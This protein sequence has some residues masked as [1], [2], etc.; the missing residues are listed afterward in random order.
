MLLVA[1]SSPLARA[2]ENVIELI[3]VAGQS[4]AVGFD[5]HAALLPKSAHDAEVK[6]WFRC[7]DPPVDD[8]DVSSSGKW[9]TLVSQPKGSPKEKGSAP[10]QYGNFAKPEGGFGPEIGMARTLRERQPD[11]RIAVIKVAFSGTAIGTDWNPD[12]QDGDVQGDCYRALISEAKTAIAAVIAAGESVHLRAFVWVQGE[13]DA[14]A[15]DA[16]LYARRLTH[17]I[18]SLRTELMAPD[19]IALLAVN[20][21]FS[22]GKNKHMPSIIGAQQ[23]VAKTDPQTVYIDTSKATTANAVHY[24]AQGTLDVGKWFAEGLIKLEAGRVPAATK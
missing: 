2:D 4:N 19:M 13:S 22:A 18:A 10:R 16:P 6:F 24:D 9:I 7:G 23:A 12:A 8:H 11:R 5:A 21:Q 3:L 1:A 15:A 17:L 20:T 14:N